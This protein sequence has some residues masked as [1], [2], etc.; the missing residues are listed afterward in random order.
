MRL[1]AALAMVVAVLAATPAGA[2]E[3]P[4]AYPAPPPEAYPAPPIQQPPPQPQP[5]YQPGGQPPPALPP[6]PV[7]HTRPSTRVEQRIAIYGELLGKGVVYGIGMDVNVTKW[8]GFGGAFSYY[9]IDDFKAGLFAPY[10]AFYAGGYSSAFVAH[11][12]PE[13]LFANT[14]S[15]SVW[16]G[17]GTMVVGQ[18]SVGYEYRNGFLF[19]AML[20][21]FFTKDDAIAWP[22]FTFG[23]AF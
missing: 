4:D 11:V 14:G 13:I 10:V 18:A 2:Q 9:S 8:L 22:G 3:P 15:F 20:G 6:P 21:L 1:G 7:I 19:R 16:G 5:G 17:E 12:G 23:G